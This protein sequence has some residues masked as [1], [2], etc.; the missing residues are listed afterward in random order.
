MTER[1][2]IRE[3]YLNI[4]LIILIFHVL[5]TFGRKVTT[6]KMGITNNKR[7]ISLDYLEKLVY[8]RTDDVFIKPENKF[9]ES[10][11]QTVGEYYDK[12]WKH[13]R[14]EWNVNEHFIKSKFLNNTNIIQ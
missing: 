9:R 5:R 2:V 4:N 6:E 12:N 1:N 10:S 3:V 14:N 11:P 7:K 8:A 13:C